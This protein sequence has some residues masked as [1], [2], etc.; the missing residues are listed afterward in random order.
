M[1]L[2]ALV[3]ITNI[4][5]DFVLPQTSQ[6]PVVMIAGGIGITPFRSML[7]FYSENHLDFKIF[8]LYSNRDQES[9]AFIGELR[10]IEK[11]NPSVKLI[12]TMTDD[13]TWPGES[14]RIDSQFIKAY[15]DNW[16]N[17]SYLVAGPPAMVKAVYEELLRLGV[18]P[19]KIKFE[20]FI[21][22]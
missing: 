3:E 20:E 10:Q 12:L 1:P 16:Q 17:S 21:G 19:E 7:K 14:R 5:G 13:P 8:L 4:K 15:I 6:V 22:Y 9:A 11:D 2:G 18:K